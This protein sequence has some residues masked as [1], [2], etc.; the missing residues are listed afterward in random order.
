MKLSN[1][2]ISKRLLNFLFRTRQLLSSIIRRCRRRK[3]TR[4]K[5]SPIRAILSRST[6]FICLPGYTTSPLLVR[7]FV[8]YSLKCLV[9]MKLVRLDPNLS[10][11]WNYV[12]TTHP[13]FRLYIFHSFFFLLLYVQFYSV[14]YIHPIRTNVKISFFFHKRLTFEVWALRNL[15]KECHIQFEFA[16]MGIQSLYK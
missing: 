9:W 6:Q 15:T 5:T 8:M 16:S 13:L 4:K 7:V 2:L 3:V 1:P 10:V 12:D 11:L 14:L